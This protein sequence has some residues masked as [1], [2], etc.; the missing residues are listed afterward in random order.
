MVTQDARLFAATIRDNVACSTPRCPARVELAASAPAFTTTSRAAVA[1]TRCSRTAARR[2]REASASAWHWRERCCTIPRVVLDEATSALD[3]VTERRVQEQLAALRCTRVVIAH[4][5]STIVGADRIMVLERGR[6][7]GVGRHAELLASCAGYRSLIEAQAGLTELA[8]GHGKRATAGPPI[9]AYATWC[10]TRPAHATGR[11]ARV[12]G[13]AEP[14]AAGG[15]AR[16]L[17]ALP[18]GL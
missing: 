10:R 6:V 2:C 11:T 9:T 18:G 12:L 15:A 7:L 5:L 14:Y 1:T 4:R 16:G 13:S 17:R 3:T 8:G